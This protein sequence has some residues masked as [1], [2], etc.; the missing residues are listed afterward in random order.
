M[1]IFNFIG[2][3][4]VAIGFG[5]AFGI[6]SLLGLTAEGPL[7]MIAGPLLLVLDLG[8]RAKKQPPNWFHPRSG[9]HLFWLPV[10]IWGL[11]W[12]ALGLVYVLR[13]GST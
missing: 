5:V 6:G 11:I 2:I 13:G 7:M 8:Y 12:S 9:G 1:I 4:M 3:G 10:W